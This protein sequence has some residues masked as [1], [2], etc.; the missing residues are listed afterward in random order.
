MVEENEN[1]GLAHEV[2]AAA[3]KQDVSRYVG[4][5]NDA[6]E[7]V[8]PEIDGALAV[9]AVVLL[10]GRVRYRGRS[11]AGD[12]SPAGWVL[13]FRDGKVS[14]FRAFREPEQTLEAAGLHR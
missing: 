11:G 12:E 7:V 9:G 2:F 3:A 4:D 6:G 5:L 10:V 8:S 14:S 13:K 1:V